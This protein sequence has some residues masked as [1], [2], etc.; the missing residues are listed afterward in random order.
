VAHSKEIKDKVRSNYIKGFGL[1]AAA[2]LSD[3]PYGTAR[4]WK[5]AASAAGD[6]WDRARTALR[7]SKGSASE[8]TSEIV[9]DFILTFKACIGEIK[10]DESISAIVKAQT[11]SQ[12][13]DAYQKAVKAMSDSNP[14]LSKLSVVMDVLKRQGEFVRE[15]Y[16]DLFEAYATM[17]DDFGKELANVYS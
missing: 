11:L 2:A 5:R 12:L 10:E 4:E 13:S 9:E 3:V 1:K 7:L 15:H 6:D 14:R 16:P 17:L 8:L